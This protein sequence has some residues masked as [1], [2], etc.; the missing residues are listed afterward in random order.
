MISHFRDEYDV[1][2]DN[3]TYNNQIVGYTKT[4]KLTRSQTKRP[5]LRK[6]GLGKTKKKPFS[7]MRTA[8]MSVYIIWYTS[9]VRNMPTAQNSSGNLPSYPPD[10]HHGSVVYWSEGSSVIITTVKKKHLILW[11]FTASSYGR[12]LR[13]P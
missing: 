5:E 10:N 7:C 11:A 9:V 3:Q 8:H 2:T 13:P 6:K 1:D 12:L 4:Q